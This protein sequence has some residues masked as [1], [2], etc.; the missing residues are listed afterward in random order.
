MTDIKCLIDAI[1]VRKSVRSYSRRQL[2]EDIADSVLRFA[3]SLEQPISG[4]RAR[5]EL[6][7]HDG[8]DADGEKLGT[9]RKSVV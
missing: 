7:H 1:N 5:V 2:E 3:A 6:V 9:D 4:C 8:N